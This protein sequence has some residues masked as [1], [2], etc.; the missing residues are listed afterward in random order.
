MYC[1][2]CGSPVP[3]GANN[4]PNCGAPT[5]LNQQQQA[6]QQ[7]YQQQQQ[8]YQQPYQQSYSANTVDYNLKSAYVAGLLALLVG[9]FGVHNF[10]LGNTGKAVVQ[11]LITLLSCGILGVAVWIWSIIEGIMLFT[12]SIGTDAEGKPL[13]KSF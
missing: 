3:D 5:G 9:V 4:C 12:G 7:P 2:S 11:L 8:T 6:Y 1:T 10:Y 13:R